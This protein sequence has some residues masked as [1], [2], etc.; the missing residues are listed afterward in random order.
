LTYLRSRYAGFGHFESNLL[1][2]RN[3]KASNP[4]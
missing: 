1:S 4:T 3:I 2:Q